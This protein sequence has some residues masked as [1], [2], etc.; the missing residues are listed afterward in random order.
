MT[1]DKGLNMTT[2]TQLNTGNKRCM[3][4]T[5]QY[6]IKVVASSSQ[7]DKNDACQIIEACHGIVPFDLDTNL[8]GLA[9]VDNQNAAVT[10]VAIPSGGG[11][12]GGSSSNTIN[13]HEIALGNVS[14][15][16]ILRFSAM[17]RNP[18]GSYSEQTLWDCADQNFSP[19]TTAEAFKISYNSSGDGSGTNGA[20][21]L[22]FEYIDASGNEAT[23]THT[24]GNTGLDTTSF[25]GLG[26]NKVKVASTGSNNENTY[27]ITIEDSSGNDQTIIYDDDNVSRVGVYHMPTDRKAVL[28]T[29]FVSNQRHSGSDTQE[30]QFDLQF[31]DRSSG[32]KEEIEQINISHTSQD[33]LPIPLGGLLVPSGKILI[34]NAHPSSSSNQMSATVLGVLYDNS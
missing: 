17:K 30:L 15:A 5:S 12:G 2:Y 11:G 33:S 32:I 7:P 23:A 26:I 21:T 29:I 22:D 27:S 8:W 4:Q 3:V 31:L 34:I 1:I 9:T 13:Y 20:L 24:L 19:I 16:S 18:S 6:P 28:D 14:G 25:T 10:E